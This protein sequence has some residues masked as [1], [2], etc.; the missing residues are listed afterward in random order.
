MDKSALKRVGPGFY[1]DPNRKIYFDVGEFIAA[2]K[3]PDTPEVRQKVWDEI[4]KDFGVIG[5]AELP[6]P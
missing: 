2:H 3:L 6:D 4:R 1:A 5:V